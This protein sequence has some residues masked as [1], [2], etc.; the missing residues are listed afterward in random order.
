MVHKS[1]RFRQRHRVRVRRKY[2]C[3]KHYELDMLMSSFSNIEDLALDNEDPNS[4]TIYLNNAIAKLKRFL[5]FMIRYY[6]YKILPKEKDY[7]SGFDTY[8]YDC[9][10]NSIEKLEYISDR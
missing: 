8:G 5:P 3:K 6:E 7:R 4:Y 1:K 10:E 9:D 2:T